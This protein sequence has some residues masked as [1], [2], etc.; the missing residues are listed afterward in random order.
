IVPR[1]YVSHDPML[2]R[3]GSSAPVRKNVMAG[4][5][6]TAPVCIDFTKHRSSEIDAIC[7]R[8]SLTHAPLLPCRANLVI[9]PSTGLDFCPEVME[10]RRAPPRTS[11]G[12]SLPCHSLSL[13]L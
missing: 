3:P 7:G 1:P 8:K 10:E 13:G 2:G 5:W 6:L 11:G 4:A 12:I 9:S